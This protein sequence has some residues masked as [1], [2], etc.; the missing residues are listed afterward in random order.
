MNKPNNYTLLKGREIKGGF[1]TYTGNRVKAKNVSSIKSATGYKGMNG[2][3]FA[4]SNNHAK[5]FYLHLEQLKLSG[6]DH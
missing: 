3:P 4:N 1:N 6:R 2:T 5:Y